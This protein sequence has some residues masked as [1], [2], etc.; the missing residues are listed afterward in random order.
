MRRPIAGRGPRRSPH[1]GRLPLVL[2]AALAACATDGALPGDGP[3]PDAPRGGGPTGGPTGGPA[4]GLAAAAFCD[5]FDRPASAGGR[6]GELDPARWS[7]GRLQP[8]LP[9]APGQT[10]AIG[11]ATLPACRADLPAKVFPDHDT[12]I[13]DANEH[14]HSPHLLVAAAAQN[15][16]INS[17]RIRQPFDFAGRT[18]K[19]VFD[20]EGYNRQLLGWISI[21]VTEDPIA[22][23]SYAVLTNDEGGIIPKNG[24]E[25]QF[26]Q[27]C[28]TS[29]PTLFAVTAVHVFHDYADTIA[30]ADYRGPKQ[31]PCVAASV[32]Q[33]NHFE[34]EVSQNRVAVFVSPA[35]ADGVTFAPAA[36][37]F[38]TPVDLPFTRG[39]VH[40]STHNHA[41]RKYSEGNSMD[42]WVARWDNVGF[43][44]PILS[45]WREAEVPDA[46]SPVAG[47][48]PA[49]SIGYRVADEAQGPAQTL[50]FAGV[51]PHGATS[52]RIALSAWYLDD[53]S[54]LTNFNLR[55]RLNG[56]PWHDRRLTAG[57]I[58]ARTAPVIIGASPGGSQGAIGQMLEVPVSE[59]VSGD[60][61]LELVTA[62]VPQ[63][64]PPAVVN[65]DLILADP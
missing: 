35:S 4:C 5:T 44:G 13:C 25:L 65:V 1:F 37:M 18:G 38:E 62:G 59:L 26:N 63:N 6:A 55:Y 34:V 39:Y 21:E 19:I 57:E 23:P 3:S 56:G 24:L 30:Y 10:F 9:T 42:A 46:Q 31:A 61:R 20:A 45:G 15:Y 48:S 32:G 54:P 52:A 33:L 11:T 12:V 17:Y 40:I 49:M 43:D 27:T 50:H 28:N 2:G 41:T 58:T 7:A 22:V 29:P 8:Q 16:G 14:I 51:D 47:A 60:N 36:L 53:S 64:Y